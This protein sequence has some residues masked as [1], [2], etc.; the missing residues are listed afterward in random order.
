MT[1]RQFYPL[2]EEFRKLDLKDGENVIEFTDR[3]FNNSNGEALSFE[4][5]KSQSIT[6]QAKDKSDSDL[7]FKSLK[8]LTFTKFNAVTLEGIGEN[9][10]GFSIS[11]S[12]AHTFGSESSAIQ[13]LTFKNL[14]I[15]QTGKLDIFADSF[16]A[17]GS[18]LTV[19]SGNTATTIHATNAENQISKFGTVKTSYG[20]LNVNGGSVEITTLDL[21]GGSVNLGNS[22][23]ALQGVTISQNTT[24]N[25]SGK[26]NIYTNS[27]TKFGGNVSLNKGQLTISADSTEIDGALEIGSKDHTATASISKGS[28]AMKSSVTLNNGTLTLGADDDNKLSE[29]A[30]AGETK[31]TS[32]SGKLIMFAESAELGSVSVK[33]G[34]IQ[35][36]SGTLKMNGLTMSNGSVTLKST[37]SA[38]IGI[39]NNTAKNG[40]LTVSGGETTIASITNS[41]TINLGADKAALTKLIVSGNTTANS[42][43]TLKAYSKDAEFGTVTATGGSFELV[44]SEKATFKDGITAAAKGS[45]KIKSG[46]AAV[47]GQ[48]KSEGST[49]ELDADTVSLNDDEEYAVYAKGAGTTSIK[50]DNIDIDG[51]LFATEEGSAINLEAPNVKISATDNV[52]ANLIEATQNA[53]INIKG[54]PSGQIEID[55]GTVEVAVLTTTGGKFTVDGGNFKSSGSVQANGNSSVTLKDLTKAEFSAASGALRS[56]GGSFTLEADDIKIESTNPAGDKHVAIQSFNSAGTQDGG[57]LTITAKNSLQVDGD[58]SAGYNTNSSGEPD[59]GTKSSLSISGS[60]MTIDGKIVTFNDGTSSNNIDITLKDDKSSITGAIQNRDLK[61]NLVSTGS[62][63]TKLTLS[64]GATWTADADAS[65]PAGGKSNVKDLTIGEGGGTISTNSVEEGWIQIG[66]KKG[67]GDLTVKVTDTDKLSGDT[68]A[69]EDALTSIV[70]IDKGD[71]SYTVEAAEGDVIGDITI[72]VGK[73]GAVTAF[74][75]KANSVTQSLEDVAS[76]NILGFR[77]QMNDLDKRMGDLRSMPASDGAWARWFGGRSEYRSS[78][79]K[80]DYNAIQLGVD[81][82]FTPEVF[83]GLTF[84][85]TDNDG[86]LTNGSADSDTYSF[87]VYG[88]WLSPDGQ[89]VDVTVK[90]HRVNT[91]FS[92]RNAS[93]TLHEGS[94]GI[95]GTSFSVEYG[96]R[97]TC[98]NTGFYVEPQVEFNYGRLESADYGTSSG[99]RVHQNSVTNTVGRVGAAVGYVFPEKA[100]SVYL[101]ASWLHDWDGKTEGTRGSETASRSFSEDLGGTWGEFAMGGTYNVTNFLSAYGEVQTTTGSPIKNPWQASVGVRWSF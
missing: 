94:Y 20:T 81:H 71:K 41:G 13:A 11:S 68:A 54:V 16:D 39:V 5:S 97:F 43:S 49:V 80:N 4:G 9:Q 15:T 86:T 62:A 89:F 67:N 55:S 64:G 87:G 76:F 30:I 36:E 91:D 95:W 96:R 19:S 65:A 32:T 37:S 93:G 63:G 28:V 100:G 7:A 99:S 38:S 45:V 25:E 74:S 77:A 70:K 35:T 56:N 57:K 78:G 73:D 82:R 46:E 6:L 53:S 31:I 33:N 40:T 69:V 98:P 2:A 26:L 72:N 1:E 27:S 22:D 75:E 51:E 24:V 21:K 18:T 92:I 60:N 58:V 42:N 88:G 50:A 29:V 8:P 12:A 44:N 47:Q 66:E 84:T 79:F 10:Q 52:V 90:R 85:Y 59:I 61:G 23:G 3:A 83:A 34:T 17:S 101:K 48:I 14:S